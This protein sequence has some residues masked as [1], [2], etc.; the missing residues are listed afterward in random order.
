ML[1]TKPKEMATP[2]EE[3]Q[4]MATGIM[5]KN[6]VKIG[7]EVFKLCERKDKQTDIFITMLCALPDGE[8]TKR[9]ST[10]EQM[11]MS[12]KKLIHPTQKNMQGSCT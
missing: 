10:A 11:S 2:S 12:S 7:L 6:L 1:S 5:H 8:V 4:A 9:K 3:D